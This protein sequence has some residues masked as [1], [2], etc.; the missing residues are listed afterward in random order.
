MHEFMPK[1]Y[2][3]F[4]ENERKIERR[5]LLAERE[6]ERKTFEK[7]SAS[8]SDA[9][10]FLLSAEARAQANFLSALKLCPK[11]P[12]DPILENTL[13]GKKKVEIISRIFFIF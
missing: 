1:N 9:Q 3:N 8:A 11:P 6:R 2:Q 4:F 10:N 13:S 7:L 5:S 12:F